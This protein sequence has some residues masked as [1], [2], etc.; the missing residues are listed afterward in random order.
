L[1]MTGNLKADRSAKR[2]GETRRME[3][4]MRCC[5]GVR[6]TIN[7]GDRIDGRLLRAYTGRRG[8]VGV[9]V[10]RSPLF[11]VDR[12][13]VVQCGL[14]L[15]WWRRDDGSAVG[16]LAWQRREG[17][18]R[19]LPYFSGLTA[20]VAMATAYFTASRHVS[21]AA[22]RGGSVLWYAWRAEQNRARD[23]GRGKWKRRIRSCLARCLT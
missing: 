21:V 14:P 2:Q 5:F 19:R 20:G 23:G 7:M 11:V 16:C 18:V 17:C 3:A 10:V 13:L 6:S 22:G 4:A 15:L 9:L 1:A 8:G 12:S